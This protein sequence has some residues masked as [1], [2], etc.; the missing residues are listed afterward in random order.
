M[1]KSILVLAVFL[2]IAV[3]GWAQSR[4]ELRMQRI[5][6]ENE[7]RLQEVNNLERE[8]VHALQWNTGAFFRRVYADDFQGIL[9]SGQILSKEA[10][11]A[12]VEKSDGKYSSFVVS[13]V[14]VKMF[15]ATAVVTCLWSARGTR[16]GR[17]F[18]RQSRVT[19]VYVYGVGGWEA[20][21]SQET[22]LPGATDSRN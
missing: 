18:A 20:V 14:R 19:H 4:E 8:T 12:S 6:T 13:D 15:E 10:W 16:N 1:Q 3:C 22:L 17:E 7:S 5:A 21:S 11:I 2:L 9:P